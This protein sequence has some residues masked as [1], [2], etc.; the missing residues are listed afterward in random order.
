MFHGGVHRIQWLRKKKAYVYKIVFAG[1]VN[2]A[3]QG[4]AAKNGLG[5]DPDPGTYSGTLI[6]RSE[7]LLL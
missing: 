1:P 3:A 7:V 5:P 4:A 6:L 2:A